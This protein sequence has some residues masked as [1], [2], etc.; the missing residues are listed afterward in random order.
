MKSIDVISMLG[1]ENR[2]K[3]QTVNEKYSFV[4]AEKQ[5]L[6]FGEDKLSLDLCY[7]LNLQFQLQLDRIQPD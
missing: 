2:A 4:G 1:Y 5:K 6:F 3:N 7:R